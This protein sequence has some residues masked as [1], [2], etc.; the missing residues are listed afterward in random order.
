MR[1]GGISMNE[2]LKE[3]RRINEISK[4]GNPSIIKARGTWK[5]SDEMKVLQLV[6]KIITPL[7]KIIYLYIPTGL[8]NYVPGTLEDS[9]GYMEKKITHV[10]CQLD[11]MVFLT[12]SEYERVKNIIDTVHA[13][14]K[15][16][17]G[18]QSI[19]DP[20][21]FQLNPN[22]NF[23]HL[24]YDLKFKPDM[25]SWTEDDFEVALQ[26]PAFSHMPS[27]TE[28]VSKREQYL[29]Y[30]HCY[31]KVRNFKWDKYDKSDVSPEDPEDIMLM[32]EVAYTLRLVFIDAFP[33]LCVD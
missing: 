3:S 26:V 18:V 4:K 32:H 24:C 11:S 30:L 17:S 13:F 28:Q 12:H 25:K 29:E 9:W 33:E 16:Y 2:S 10:Y 6:E 27:S 31:S 21:W 19:I 23:F 7:E 20:H 1:E 15:G 8:Y 5:I 14:V 22:L